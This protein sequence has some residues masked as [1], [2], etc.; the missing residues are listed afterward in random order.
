MMKKIVK[1]T[2][3]LIVV[4]L[5]A[6]IVTPYAFRGKLLE[7]T[8]QEINNNINATVAFDKFSV[9]LFR[10]FPDFT[11]SMSDFS[12]IGKDSFALDTL[13]YFKELTATVDIMS[14]FSGDSIGIKRIFIDSP[15]LHA[16]VAA[17]GSVNY[18]IFFESDSDSLEVD[19]TSSS[20]AM[21][22][23]DITI[24][25][26]RVEYNDIPYNM[27]A[28]FD[29]VDINISGD[30]TDVST[31]IKTA[32]SAQ[33]CTFKMDGISY[34]SHAEFSID[35]DIDAD[36]DA[37]KYTL[38]DNEMKI[39]AL[40]LECN[41]WLQF[42]DDD[43][44]MDFTFE[45]KKTDFKH[46]LSL[47]P[48]VFMEGFEDIS[49]DGKLAL[50]G[51]V[52]GLYSDSPELYPSF[53]LNL[54]VEN[55]IFKYPDVPKSVDNIF[56]DLHI[57]SPT[58]QL[59]NMTIDLKKLTVNFA[60]NPFFASF[61][62]KNPLSDPYMKAALKGN[63]D[64]HSIADFIPLEETTLTGGITTDISFEARMSDIEKENYNTITA[65][66]NIAI[67]D[68]SYVDTDFPEGIF[69][70]DLQS[71][72]SPQFVYLESCKIKMGKSDVALS[73]RLEN[74][75]PYALANETVRGTL[76]LYSHFIDA[77]ELLG[78]E[79]ETVETDTISEAYEII[80][81]PSNIDFELHTKIDRL[82]YDVYDIKNIKGIV[83]VRNSTVSMENL[84][85]NMLQGA[86]Q[87]SGKYA[88]P[89]EEKPVADF[90][91]NITNFDVAQSF[92]TF[93]TVQILAP[94]IKY[95]QGAFSTNL[96]FYSNLEQDF[97]PTLSSINGSG[98]IKTNS[99]ELQ[100]SKL[101]NL[102][103]NKLKQNDFKTIQAKNLNLFFEI[104]NGNIIIHPFES[105]L[106][107]TNTLIEGKSGLDQSLDYKIALQIP[108]EKMGS[109]TNQLISQLSTSAASKGID[110]Q[111]ADFIDLTMLVG[112][113]IKNPTITPVLGNT[114]SGV[115]NSVK[116]Q[117]KQKL[118][119]EQEKL[120]QE[121]QARLNAA[122]AKAEAE[123]ARRKKE[124]EAKAKAEIQKQAQQVQEK[125]N[126]TKSEIKSKAKSQIRDALKR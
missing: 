46:F 30:F 22:L 77:N 17:D 51:N 61:F 119:A 15:Y 107:G 75:I 60:E 27:Y 20:F 66:G 52:R 70:S 33:A 26:A 65:L 126:E 68:F 18:D 1:I 10:D 47:I 92:E 53:Q 67:Q 99:I 96:S 74:F 71:T 103:V 102:I 116:S 34:L 41:G 8:K 48:G 88:T 39:N 108:R 89:P 86:M 31:Q 42:E 87:M 76:D 32:M 49:A 64:L 37:E 121:A 35:A 124:A 83:T 120:Q 24:K 63:I 110:I 19:T 12:I 13:V 21:Q 29:D 80:T 25:N 54:Q 109:A 79:D 43:M 117:A 50:N 58:E 123:A 9:R 2:S 100:N 94:I 114:T 4:I 28:L 113:T 101:Q 14:L 91:L 97:M 5:I 122:K 104:I 72:F 69:I 40:E 38:R 125:I 36:F 115:F 62:M 90:S 85:L 3:I 55:G 23:Q 105:N 11:V 81:V 111:A 7:I 45:T 56:L 112:G 6:L 106:N 98:K 84:Q 93:T 118:Q 95:M 73:G 82:L 44:R 78:E 59:D 57:N 16:F